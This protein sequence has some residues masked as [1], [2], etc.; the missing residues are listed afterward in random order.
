MRVKVL[1]QIGFSPRVRWLIFE[2][3][4]RCLGFEDFSAMGTSRVWGDELK[5]ILWHFEQTVPIRGEDIQAFTGTIKK[6]LRF[7]G[8][9]VQ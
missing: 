1:D 9:P 5:K 4:R 8:L 2:G 6:S 3:V 7:S